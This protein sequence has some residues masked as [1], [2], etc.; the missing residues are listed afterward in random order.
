[1]K[2]KKLLEVKFALAVAALVSPLAGLLAADVAQVVSRQLWPWSTDVL[3]TYSLTGTETASYDIECSVLKDGETVPVPFGAIDWYG[4]FGV[5]PGTTSSFKWDPSKTSLTN[6]VSSNVRVALTA[7]NVS[8]IVIDVSGGPDAQSYPVTILNGMPAGGWTD[9]YK[10]TKIVLR[11][12]PAGTFMMGSPE[13]EVGRDSARETL[14]E[15]TLTYDFYIGV[16]EITCKQFSLVTGREI[17][18]YQN[19]SEKNYDDRR[20][21]DKVSYAQI[22]GATQGARFPTSS[23]VDGDSFLGLLRAKTASA[24]LRQGYCFDLPTDAEWEYACRGGTTTSLNNGKNVSLGVDVA[25]IDDALAEV[26]RYKLPSDY[27]TTDLVGSHRPNAL[28]LYDMHGNV[29]EICL[30]WSVA[31]LGRASVTNPVGP[32]SAY[33]RLRRGGSRYQYAYR[34]RSA[35]RQTVGA[36][37][38]GYTWGFRLAFRPYLGE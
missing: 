21:A 38:V 37:D 34:H 31:D 35:N 19:N 3:V 5:V 17:S 26:A 13:D 6:C 10:T 2:L 36:S 7:T 28:G 12:V 8:Y 15:V 33:N 24:S 16:F 4:R 20:P 25:G 22:R 1:M 14:H 27:G 11:R 9:E 30:D 18:A 32:T 23:A 29:E